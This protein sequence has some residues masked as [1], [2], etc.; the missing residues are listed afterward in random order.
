VYPSIVLGV[1]AAVVGRRLGASAVPARW[2]LVALAAAAASGAALAAGWDYGRTA[3]LFAISAVMALAA[4]GQRGR[5]GEVA[6]GMSYPLY[7][8]HW[9]GVL[10]GNA[11]L[12]RYGL[13]ESAWRHAS[14]FA[15]SVA[16]AVG[17]YAL[18]DRRLL[19]ARPRLYSHR[20]GISAIAIGYGG[21][22]VGL[23]LAYGVFGFR[24][25]PTP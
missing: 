20:L 11:I 22:L 14:S 4:K 15:F 3:P 10:V 17:L 5:L 16:L 23:V 6:G 7:L 13:R 9:I 25:G 1:L 24:G 8:N 12:G 19:A 18:V 21:V 2:R